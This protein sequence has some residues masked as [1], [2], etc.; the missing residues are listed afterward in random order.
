MLYK[1]IKSNWIVTAGVIL[2]RNFTNF[3]AEILNF[4]ADSKKMTKTKRWKHSVFQ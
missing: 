4:Y 3:Y 1:V 2:A